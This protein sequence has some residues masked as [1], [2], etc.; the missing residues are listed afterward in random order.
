MASPDRGRSQHGTNTCALQNSTRKLALDETSTEPQ[1]ESGPSE[2]REM[3]RAGHD[4][5][6][7]VFTEA[8]AG[9]RVGGERREERN[10]GQK[11]VELHTVRCC[12]TISSFNSAM[13]PL[14]TTLPRSM[15]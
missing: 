15:M 7:P 8:V 11:A 9:M 4:M 10:Q 13:G 12:F 14:A 2:K 5:R 6:S 1:R 3:I